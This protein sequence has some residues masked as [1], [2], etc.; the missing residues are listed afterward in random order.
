[1][2]CKHKFIHIETTSK[3]REG[4]TS[5]NGGIPCALVSCV[6]CAQTRKV[7][8]DGTVTIEQEGGTPIDEDI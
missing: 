6:N 2:I 1:M 8:A 4:S 3:M 7:C 5:Y